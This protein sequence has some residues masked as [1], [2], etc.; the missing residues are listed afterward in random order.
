VLA[1]P[2]YA[3]DPDTLLEHRLFARLDV[4][5]AEVA[6]TALAVLGKRRAAA[7][8]AALLRLVADLG[9]FLESEM[10]DEVISLCDAGGAA[11]DLLPIVLHGAVPGTEKAA[12]VLAH[13][14]VIATAAAEEALLELTRLA[15]YSR[16]CVSVINSN[17]Y[18]NRAISQTGTIPADVR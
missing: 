18:V 6:A 9:A 8:D 2:R 10:Y 13:A 1:K 11:A 14:N 3:P 15:G 7:L 4:D 17:V 12:A 5:T 16:H